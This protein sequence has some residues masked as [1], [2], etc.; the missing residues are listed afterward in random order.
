MPAKKKTAATPR[1]LAALNDM[2][3]GFIECHTMGHQW[4]RVA[5]IGA[6]EQVDGIKRPYGRTGGM[7]GYHSQCT[8][9]TTFRIAWITRSGDKINRYGY[10]DGYSR[11]GGDR[12]THADYRRTYAAIL[13]DE[14]KPA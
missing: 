10:V 2:P 1:G 4:H 12:V 14:Y 8:N 11:R 3:V 6:D 9:C 13:F 5:T 7:L